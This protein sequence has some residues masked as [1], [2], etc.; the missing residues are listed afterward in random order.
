V[1]KPNEFV[2]KST[3]RKVYG[4]TP[5][6]IEELGEPDKYCENPHWRGGP[7]ARLYSIERVKTW[8]GANKERVERARE[9]RARRSAAARTAQER[10]QAERRRE[11]ERLLREQEGRRR[12]ALDWVNGLVVNLERRLPDTLVEDARRTHPNLTEKALRAH[13][14]HRLTNYHSL[15]RQLRSQEFE[16]EL[17]RLLRQRTDAVMQAAIDEWRRQPGRELGGT[18]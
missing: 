14:R 11:R 12:D 4:L 16:G 6:M 10:K 15:R 8:V 2:Y 7:D 9:S 1:S 18:P 3:V 5:A 13:V 17:D